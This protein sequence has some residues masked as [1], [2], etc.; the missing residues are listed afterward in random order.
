MKKLLRFAKIKILQSLKAF[1]VTY[2]AG[3]RQSGKTTLA[4][5]IASGIY[6]LHY[7]TFDDLQLQSAAQ[8]DPDAFLNSFNK[9]VVLDEIQMVPELFRPLKSK[10]TLRDFKHIETLQHELGDAFHQGFVVYQG[11]DVL[12]F[13]KNMWAIPFAKLWS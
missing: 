10:V 13:G 4:Q 9:P 1:P 6:P 12:S 2:I 11:N 3:P 7:F 5:G 8:H